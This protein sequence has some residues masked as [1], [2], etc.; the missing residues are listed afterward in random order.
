MLYVKTATSYQNS[1]RLVQTNSAIG[2]YCA[3]S[4]CWGPV[5]KQ[6][7]R[8]LKEN[9][10]DH[11]SGIPLGALPRTFREAVILTRSLGID[12]LWIDSLCIL[13]DDDDDWAHEAASMGPLYQQATLVI[14]AAGSQDP[15]G[16]LFIQERFPKIAIQLSYTGQT[17]QDSGTFNMALQSPAVPTA[18]QGPLQQR[19]WALQEW[20][21]AQRIV[22]FMPEGFG[23]PGG[24]SWRCDTLER[25]ENGHAADLGI[26]EDEDWLTLLGS[27]SEKK[28]T[29]QSD[30][31]VALEGILSEER[32][33]RPYKFLTEGVWEKDIPQQLLWLRTSVLIYDTPSLPSWSWASTEGSKFWISSIPCGLDL[34]YDCVKIKRSRPGRLSVSGDVVKA[35]T[36]RWTEMNNC[37]FST[38]KAKS[39]TG[40]YHPT[41]D[42]FETQRD[43]LPRF[44]YVEGEPQ[45]IL[46]QKG[47][48]I[49]GFA[50]MDQ[51][52]GFY[53]STAYQ[54]LE[55]CIMGKA[56]SDE[57]S[58]DLPET[59]EASG[60]CLSVSPDLCYRDA[61][62]PT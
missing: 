11:Y 60:R 1:V 22:F 40:Y 47:E 6:P 55:C 45:T 24:I 33:Q 12:Y 14:A 41:S 49:L 54:T 61:S 57:D 28:L 51:E 36:V 18:N 21:L 50:V 4:H 13:Q 32:K 53:S 52:E 29:R 38:F 26:Y 16:G 59:S 5:D 43:V 3:L 39:P 35:S 2:K 37:C 15:T 30:R 58:S 34:N 25:D 9:I 48:G 19:A 20:H 10:Q 44:D 62:L 7:I 27:Y 8:T 17:G 23:L 31:L 56:L 46:L 42:F